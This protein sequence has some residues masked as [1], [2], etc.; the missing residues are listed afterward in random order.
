MRALRACARE[1]ELYVGAA[2]HEG[3]MHRTDLHGLAVVTDRKR[4][5][6]TTTPGQLSAALQLSPSATSALLDRLERFGHVRRTPH[7]ADRRSV[8]VEITEHALQTGASV[9]G[10]L[11]ARFAPLLHSR[12]EDELAAISAFVEE[13]VDA[14]RAARADL[15]RS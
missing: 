6:Q 10:P 12:S 13:A 4:L 14:T 15:G 1:I 7:P 9:F 11:G 3:E 8:V 2:G 5:G